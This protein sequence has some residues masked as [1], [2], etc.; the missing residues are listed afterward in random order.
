MGTLRFAH[1]T[2]YRLSAGM[3]G[4]DGADRSAVFAIPNA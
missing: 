4:S 1:R 2:G 3:V